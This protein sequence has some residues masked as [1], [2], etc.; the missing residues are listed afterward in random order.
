MQRSA[1]LLAALI[2]I[3]GLLSAQAQES[4]A[5][6]FIQMDPHEVRLPSTWS[7]WDAS[8]QARW[9]SGAF[10]SGFKSQHP[11]WQV[12]FDPSN[13]SIHR[14][15]GPAI[16]TDDPM[17]W[18]QQMISESGWTVEMGEWNLSLIHI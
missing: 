2:F 13:G 8:M 17:A 15:Y 11:R 12:Q 9:R 4:M 6:P 14:A 5:N 3:Q 16:S 18:L 1:Q 7:P 10:W